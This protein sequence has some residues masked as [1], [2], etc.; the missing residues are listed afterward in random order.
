MSNIRKSLISFW[1]KNFMKHMKKISEKVGAFITT[2]MTL[3][4]G[5]FSKMMTT[6]LPPLWAEFF[7]GV[8]IVFVSMM[9]FS[10]MK[11]MKNGNGNTEEKKD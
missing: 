4:V 11:I 2:T 7:I 9:T 10:I 3:F 5:V 8:Y 6:S 1:K